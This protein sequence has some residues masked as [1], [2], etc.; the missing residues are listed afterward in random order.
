MNQSHPSLS[1]RV[2]VPDDVLFQ[3]LNGEA[4]LL[5]V[6]TGIYFGLDRVGTRV[7]QLLAEHPVPS[8]IIG[9]L[10]DEFD[11]ERERCER[12]VL[13]LLADMA[14]HGLVTID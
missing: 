9:P 5:N 11:V 8:A 13:S 2:R 7:W 10:V 4:V 12:D 1:S 3:D 14:T 6:K